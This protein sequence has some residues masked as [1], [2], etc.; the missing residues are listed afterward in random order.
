MTWFKLDDGFHSHPKVLQAG[1]E[2]IGLY[3]RCGSYCAQHL[4]DGFV[5]APVVLLYGSVEL[6]EALVEARLWKPVKGGWQMHDYLTYNPS[7]EK[8]TA[9]RDAAAERQRRARERR[10][11]EQHKR[12]GHAVTST[13]TDTDSCHAV[14]HGEVTEDVTHTVTDPS[15]CPD[16]T[17][18][19]PK[20]RTTPTAP[21]ERGTRIPEDFTPTPE[22]VA[23]ARQ[24]CPDVD[25]RWATAKFIDHWASKPGKDGLKIDW[26]KTWR[27]WMRTEQERAHARR[28][29]LQAV[30][31]DPA[32]TGRRRVQM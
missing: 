25:G 10:A 32:I 20:K 2:A 12:D 22:M 18:P 4:T 24:E 21:R 29:R 5:P 6:A 28:P 15:Q 31:T 17:R 26:A 1:N 9:E 13:V 11:A 30:P 8:V 14:T 3:V 27:N 19:D 7:R 23:W 16:P